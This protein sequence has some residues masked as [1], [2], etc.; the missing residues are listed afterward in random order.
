MT[1]SATSSLMSRQFDFLEKGAVNVFVPFFRWTIREVAKRISLLEK[2]LQPELSVTQS[3]EIAIDT[4]PD[5][6]ARDRLREAAIEGLFPAFVAGADTEERLQKLAD[7][8]SLKTTTAQAIAA[9]LGLTEVELFGAIQQ[10]FAQQ[11]ALPPR[12]VINAGRE[13]LESTLNEPYWDW[14]NNTTRA[15]IGQTLE[16]AM[17]KRMKPSTLAKHLMNIRGADYS[18]TRAMTVARTELAAMRNAGVLAQI[19]H[20]ENL[21]GAPIKRIWVAKF[22]NTR[23]DHADLDSVEAGEDGQWDLGGVRIPY[24]AHRSLPADQRINCQCV[25]MSEATSGL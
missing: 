9:S 3:A 23:D 12:D 24:P 20:I 8:K 5:E 7:A 25:L 10:E 16:R 18:E 11:R 6:E 14:I 17:R 4:F 21:S 15:D 1:S 19:E 13:S 22:Q 2:D